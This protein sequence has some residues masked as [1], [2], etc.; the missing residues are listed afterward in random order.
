MRLLNKMRFNV[1]N[2]KGNGF[3]LTHR[4][5]LPV[6]EGIRPWMHDDEIAVL[7]CA[8]KAGMRVLEWGGGGSTVLAAQ[9]VGDAGWLD[10][11]E[12]NEAFANNVRIALHQKGVDRYSKVH[13]VPPNHGRGR[14]RRARPGQFDNYVNKALELGFDCPYDVCII[15]GRDRISCALTASRVLKPGAYMFFHDF[16]LPSRNRYRERLSELLQHYELCFQIKH[17]PQTMAIFR[18]K[19]I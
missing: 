16:A 17:T 4:S 1:E 19:C 9:C 5:T 15:D 2:L 10:S 6:S 8:I 18:K 3:D 7:Q 13:F 12:H 11:I 14:I